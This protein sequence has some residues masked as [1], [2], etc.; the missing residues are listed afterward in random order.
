M[1]IKFNLEKVLFSF[2]LL[3]PAVHIFLTAFMP[4]LTTK[5]VILFLIILYF[6]F[7]RN[8]TVKN[9]LFVNTVIIIYVFYNAFNYNLV[10]IIHSDFYSFI[11]LGLIFCIYGN[12]KIVYR[13]YDF[14]IKRKNIFLFIESSFL[15]TLVYSI[16]FQEG[17]KVGF[18]SRIPVLYGPYDIPHMLG[19]ILIVLYCLNSI[20]QR[21]TSSKIFIMLK[22]LCIIL[23]I[24]TA[25]RSAVL[26]IAIIIFADYV[27]IKKI[28]QKFIILNGLILV[29]L[30]LILFTDILINNP[31]IQKTLASIDGGSITNGRRLFMNIALDYYNNDSIIIEKLFGIGMNNL[32]SIFLYTSTIRVAIHAH[33]DY[34]N[35]LVG[36]GF[37]G[38]VIF[39]IGQLGQIKAL[40]SPSMKLISQVFIFVL[41]YYNGLAM[42]S[43]FTPCLIILYVF[44]NQPH[45]LESQSN[46]S[47]LELT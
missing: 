20:F 32:R 31:L 34:V 1:R 43:M 19:Y 23:V 42:Y 11:L 14:L 16:I 39:V 24:W 37:I 5:V 2:I 46:N 28:K 30:F 29:A 41:A 44:M 40:I 3:F 9:M 4:S 35:A 22:F 21:E 7:L 45:Y 33:N 18:G 26:G 47:Q 38:F 15:L 36:Y 10:Q 17:L 13:Y 25:A 6:Y 12:K 27:M 8:S